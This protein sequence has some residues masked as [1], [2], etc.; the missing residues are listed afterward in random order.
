MQEQATVERRYD[1]NWPQLSS[2]F[3][4]AMNA[5][6]AISTLPDCLDARHSTMGLM[7][8]SPKIA[9]PERFCLRPARSPSGTLSR[10]TFPRCAGEGH[11]LR[12][13]SSL[14][15]PSDRKRA[16]SPN[17]GSLS[18][19]CRSDRK[20]ARSANRSFLALSERSQALVRPTAGLVADQAAL[21]RAARHLH[22]PVFASRG[23]RKWRSPC[24]GMDR[25]C[26]AGGG[27]AASA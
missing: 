23:R 17:R 2:I 27:W 6:C 21:R 25:I 13:V 14:L 3:S 9:P 24:G 20:R 10:A 22:P 7:A 18:L 5:S 15:C 11:R 8:F 19:L 16:R 4:A 12:D 26:S 1:E